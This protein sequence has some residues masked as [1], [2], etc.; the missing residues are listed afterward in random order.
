[1]KKEVLKEYDATKR[2]LVST[3]FL[4]DSVIDHVN[5]TRALSD[6]GCNVLGVIDSKYT[7]KHNLL[8]IPI[9][10][11]EIY[12]YD[13]HPAEQVEAIVKVTVDIGGVTTPAFL[14]EVTHMED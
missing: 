5:N 4:V 7:R 11:Q 3:S 12:A 6:T 8:H 14:Y 10:P 2:D 1:M 9:Q 13:N